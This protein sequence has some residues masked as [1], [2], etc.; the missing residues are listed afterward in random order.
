[1]H[2]WVRHVSKAEDRPGTLCA[3]AVF[4]FASAIVLLGFQGCAAVGPAQG[5]TPP[6]GPPI[7]AIGGPEPSRSE[8]QRGTRLLMAAGDSLISGAVSKGR[9]FLNDRLYRGVIGVCAGFLVV[10]AGYFVYSGVN[11]VIT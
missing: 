6:A 7:P 1:M 3:R 2:S 8:S 4:I 11:R 9:R 5:S 10:F